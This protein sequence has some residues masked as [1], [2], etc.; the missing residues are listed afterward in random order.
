[1][2]ATQNALFVGLISGTSMDGIDAGVFRFADRRLQCLAGTTLDYPPDLHAQLLSLRGHTGSLSLDDLGALDAALGEQFAHAAKQIIA[3][4]GLSPTDITA[5]GSHGQTVRH[6]P[7]A[8]PPYT[9]QLADP[10]VIA[11]QTGCT[12]VADFRRADVARGG[13]GAP[14]LPLLHDWLFADR[15][16][17]V[18]VVNLGGIA[19]L[20]YLPVDGPLVAF[21]TGPAN[22][23]VDQWLQR[24]TGEPF[25]EGGGRAANGT[26]HTD[27]L[28]VLL[29][30]DY[31]TRPPPK[32][33]GFE[34]FNLPWLE[35]RQALSDGLSVDDV[36]A[37]LTELSACSI[38]NA[39]QCCQPQP[40][41]VWLAGGGVHNR[42][43]VAS[44]VQRLPAASVAPIS[45]LG[46]DADQLEAAGFA[47]LA[48][49]RLAGNFTR[50]CEVTGAT[51]P[52]LLGTVIASE[53]L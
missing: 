40:T 12:V 9:L 36:I 8:T 27:W 21:D 4:S 10:H 23:L 33:T 30:D 50:H 1:M 16:A 52:T 15:T 39:I 46:I 17:P 41:Q 19:N 45:T 31:F 24:H 25:D 48:R 37:T 51:S 13:E 47:W 5:I 34:Y 43:L 44:L 29:D 18:A 3:A 11:A 35:R 20:T 2:T 42:S 28:D 14:L 22:T 32:S 6:N 49:E 7:Q 38:A 53:H 26:A